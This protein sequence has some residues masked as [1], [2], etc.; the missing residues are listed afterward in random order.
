MTRRRARRAGE[1]GAGLIGATAG[2][3]VV[4][5]FVLFAV[6]LLVRLHAASL[7]GSAA[8]A[9]ARSVATAPIGPGDPTATAAARAEAEVEVRALLGDAGRTAELDWTETDGDEVVLRVRVE[10]PDVLP[11]AA[12]VDLPFDVVERTARV[13]VERVR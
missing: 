11:A 2:L 6:H 10:V 13:R 12:G 9:G 3:V 7:V 1:R 5:A 4:V 8:T